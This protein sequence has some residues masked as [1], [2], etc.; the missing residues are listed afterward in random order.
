MPWFISAASAWE[1][2]NPPDARY[3][4][5]SWM[6]LSETTTACSVCSAIF[7]HCTHYA[8]TSYKLPLLLSLWHRILKLRMSHTH[9]YSTL[10]QSLK[11]RRTRIYLWTACIA[12]KVPWMHQY[13]TDPVLSACC[14]DKSLD[15]RHEHDLMIWSCLHEDECSEL[16][17]YNDP[18][19]VFW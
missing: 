14:V 11:L 8:V 15:Q 19:R 2:T 3:H 12:E 10:E 4:L 13:L 9:Q 16:T 7:A 1:G 18:Q 5:S 17:S 6:V